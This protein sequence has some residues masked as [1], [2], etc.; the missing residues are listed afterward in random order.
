M[1]IKI[2]EQSGNVAEILVSGKLLP[3]DYQSFTPEFERLVQKHG[4]LRVLFEMADFHGWGDGALWKEIKFDW[5]HLSDM[6]RIAVAGDRKWEQ[7]ITAL[8]RPF[9][10]AETRYFDLHEISAAK[11]WLAGA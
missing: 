9:L 11:I 6:E 1:P 5:K 3:A 2:T 8:S 7:M 4:K 10:K